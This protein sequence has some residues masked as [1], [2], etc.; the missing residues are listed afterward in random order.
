MTEDN[1]PSIN[2]ENQKYK[3]IFVGDQGT[4]KTCILNRF[5]TNQ[6]D[7]Q[8]QTTIGLDFQSKNVSI[9]DQDVRLLLYDTAGQEKFRSLIPM[10]IR[11][12]NIILLVYDITRKESFDNIPRWFSDVLNI[13]SNEAIYVLVGN[14]IDLKDQRKVTYNE[15]KKLADEK[16]I[17]FEEVSAKT[18]ENFEELFRDKIYESIYKKYKNEFE[19]RN[20][21]NG[22]ELV[23]NLDDEENKNKIKIDKNNFKKKSSKKSFCC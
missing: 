15:G 17:I 22:D 18:G 6:F 3:M 1:E 23:V 21:L 10:Y 9:H 5:A 7:E 11:E 13:K 2:V 19:K 4:G 14:K 12:S 8:Y 16:N 20:Y